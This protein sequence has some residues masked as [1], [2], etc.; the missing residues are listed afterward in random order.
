MLLLAESPIQLV[1][2]G[3]LLLHICLILFM[4]AVLNATVFK[5]LNKILNEREQLTK[6][7]S[8][9][10]QSIM[11]KVEESLSSYEGALRAARLN[12]YALLEQE[13]AK[14]MRDRQDKLS[15]LRSELTDFVNGQK[16]TILAQGMEARATLRDEVQRIARTISAQ[17]LRR[18]L[19]RQ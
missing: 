19:S 5:P 16:Q 7:R 8:R 2:D 13:R 15:L 1:P 14:G 11:R 10:A 17:V 18:P 4:I 12:G 3:S 6:G 9:E